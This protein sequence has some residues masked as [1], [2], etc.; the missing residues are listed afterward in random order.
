[1]PGRVE[2][3]KKL[4]QGLF[5]GLGIVALLSVALLVVVLKGL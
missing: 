4:M 3:L 2:M 5:V 1:M